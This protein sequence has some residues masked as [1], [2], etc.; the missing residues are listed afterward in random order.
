MKIRKLFAAAAC[1]SILFVIDVPHVNGQ[2][3]RW[4]GTA[5]Y[6]E[7]SCRHNESEIW[8]KSTSSGPPGDNTPPFG[9]ACAFG[10]KAFCCTTPGLTCRWDGT[11]PFCDGGCGPGEQQSTPP[12]GANSGKS[13]VT[14]SKVYCCHRDET[15]G[16][17]GSALQANPAYTRYAAF[18][19]KEAGPAW[20]AGHGLSA[21]QYQQQFDRLSK[22]GYRLVEI[23]GYSVGDKDTYATIWEQRPGPAWGARHGMTAKQFQQEF[24]ARAKQGFRV[25]DLVGYTVAGEDHYAAIWEKSQGP[26]AV[27]RHGMTGPQFQQQFDALSKQ[28]Y[29]LVDISGYTFAGQEHYTAI[30]EQRKGPAWVAKSGLDSAA[31]QR[32]FNTLSQQ[33]YR[34][35][36]L[37]GWRAGDTAHF[38]AIWEKTG[39]PAW[40]ARHG[41]LSDAFQE[42]FDT[43]GKEGYRLKH[44]SGYHTYN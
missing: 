24:D 9:D 27:V 10:S 12:A 22:Q 23:S 29:R 33:G 14:G 4:D 32:E 11:A 16:S 42:E 25:V 20:S 37:R 26:A 38:A 19:D 2:T 5:P 40:V 31:Y 8:R 18:W 43:L 41:M 13:C 7:G 35:T 34:L 17:A 28:G 15:A 36:R 44:V 3:C 6:C 30:W 21:D 39:G 1:V